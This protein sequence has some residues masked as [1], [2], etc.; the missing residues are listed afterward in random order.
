M[1]PVFYWC[2]LCNYEFPLELGK[3]GCP[4]CCAD[5]GP[6]VL[7]EVD[8]SGRYSSPRFVAPGTRS[9]RIQPVCRNRPTA[10]RTVTNS[11]KPAKPAKCSNET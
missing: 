2:R 11:M 10:L 6:A 9:Q 5:D 4:S 7:V 1:V 3:Y 8:I